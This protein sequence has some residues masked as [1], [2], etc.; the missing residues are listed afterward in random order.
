MTRTGSIIISVLFSAVAPLCGAL[1][2]E[3]TPGNLH[4][5]VTD[6]ATTDLTVTGSMD[7]RDFDYIRSGLTA[8]RSLDLSDVEIVAYS[9]EPTFTGRT[10]AE[11]AVLPEGALMLPSLNRVALPA[12]LVGIA[13]GALATTSVESVS[14]PAS[15]ESI[16]R[17]AF[18]GCAGLTSVEIPGSVKNL[19]QQA[20]ADCGELESVSFAGTIKELPDG[21]FSH[22]MALK[23]V[24]LPEGLAVIGNDAFNGCTSL[25][26][27][28]LPASLTTVGDRAFANSALATFDA[29]GCTGE[30]TI[31]EW[32]F[33]NCSG[34]TE[35]KFPAGFVSLGRGAFYNDSQTPIP[36]L[37]EGLT[38]LPDYALTG[39]ATVSPE[40]ISNTSVTHIGDYAMSGW[41][42]ISSLILPATLESIGRG[43]MSGWVSL[44]E[45]DATAPVSVPLLGA[46]VWDGVDVADAV[47]K[48]TSELF[49]AFSSADQ[50]RDFNL[51]SE[52]SGIDGTQTPAPGDAGVK[53]WFEGTMLNI[54]SP[55]KI[56]AVNV[57]DV[58]GRRFTFPVQGT[59]FHLTVDT[60]A[61]GGSVMLVTVGM[62]DGASA[63]FK[64]HR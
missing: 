48:V 64:L 4:T 10:T 60:S 14:L 12:G 58:A 51:T 39:T 46:G 61:W 18:A 23:S 9:G 43:A 25:A 50:W 29:E 47:L 8:L 17:S 11:A 56:A 33:I 41:T 20:F 7:V 3:S 22:C 57:F 45:I 1:T 21:A 52:T 32:A 37:P 38:T 24:A 26:A 49:D 13:D 53:V 15:L 42:E 30:V 2:V 44:K 31:G 40:V 36:P 16:G 63:V 55:Q 54:E 59:E 6:A 5:S 28:T 19:G 35:V 27:V 34:L 62:A